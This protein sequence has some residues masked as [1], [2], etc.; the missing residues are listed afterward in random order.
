MTMLQTANV[1]CN[2]LI[3]NFATINFNNS[4]NSEQR[5]RLRAVML[6]F[7]LKIA[8][9]QEN[10]SVQYIPLKPHFYM[11]KMGYAGVCLFFFFL[12]QNIDCGYSLEQPQRGG[13]NVYPQSIFEQK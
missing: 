2:F 13:S 9:H 3:Y 10:M 12:L 8:S 11:E 5:M 6:Q 4:A 1:S 7:T